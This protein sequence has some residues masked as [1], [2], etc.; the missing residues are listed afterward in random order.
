MKSRRSGAIGP[1]TTGAGAGAATAAAGGEG[2]HRRKVRYLYAAD[3]SL[4]YREWQ[5]TPK[6][7]KLL[8]I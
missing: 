8:M 6:E 4:A 5:R 2:V 1:T 7:T 3:G